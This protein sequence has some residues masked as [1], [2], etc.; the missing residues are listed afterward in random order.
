MSGENRT[1]AFV[2]SVGQSDSLTHAPPP[3]SPE[4]GALCV[5][6]LRRLQRLREPT[7]ATTEDVAQWAADKIEAPGRLDQQPMVRHI[8]DASGEQLVGG[9]ANGRCEVFRQVLRTFTLRELS[10]T[11]TWDRWDQC[12][13]RKPRH[14][15][16]FEK[17]DERALG[18][19]EPDEL[20]A[21]TDHAIGSRSGVSHLARNHHIQGGTELEAQRNATTCVQSELTVPPDPEKV[22]RV[23][24]A[25]IY[26]DAIRRDVDSRALPPQFQW[27]VLDVAIALPTSR[28][29]FCPP[30]IHHG[31]PQ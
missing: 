5:T 28:L 11:V 30:A 31:S 23:R 8:R 29:A 10:D 13:F 2:T 27:L 6:G 19:G 9:S 12:Q 21:G 20:D 16:T 15:T 26:P 7:V 25:E 17:I 18:F 14:G 1:T 24:V 3:G 22:N 4:L